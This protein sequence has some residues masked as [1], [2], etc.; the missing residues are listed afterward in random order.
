MRG[1][2]GGVRIQLCSHILFTLKTIPQFQLYLSHTLGTLSEGLAD[3]KN[4]SELIL[5]E[6]QLQG[7]TLCALSCG[8]NQPYIR[9]LVL[10]L[11]STIFMY[12]AGSIPD[13]IGEL[14]HLTRLELRNN[15][16]TGRIPFL[17]LLMFLTV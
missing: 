7:N 4:L 15:D 16:I 8:R 12:C 10:L 2:I 13:A 6:N 5:C 9:S 11:L 17:P 1:I 14:V 3:L